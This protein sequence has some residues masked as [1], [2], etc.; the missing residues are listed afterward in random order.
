MA[1]TLEVRQNAVLLA[2]VTVP[3]TSLTEIKAALG[4]ANNNAT[5]ALFL[6]LAVQQMKPAI[7]ALIL[8]QQDAAAVTAASAAK[9]TRAA[10]FAG[11]WP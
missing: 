7:Q 9:V 6:A 10:T 4:G 1:T 8:N 11:N 2:S 5:A 3:D